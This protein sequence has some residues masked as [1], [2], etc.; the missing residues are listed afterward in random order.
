M[1]HRIPKDGIDFG[2][3]AF[4][5]GTK[6]CEHIRID[7]NG[8][9]LFRGTVKWVPHSILPEFVSQRVRELL[10]AL[11]L[12]TDENSRT[13]ASLEILFREKAEFLQSPFGRKTG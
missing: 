12:I 6:P 1:D 13:N 2:L 4:S 7:A 5:L 10:D 8:R 3:V 11:N 9:R